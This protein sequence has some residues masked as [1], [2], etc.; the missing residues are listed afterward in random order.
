MRSDS[1]PMRTVSCPETCNASR[2]RPVR[3]AMI[4]RSVAP[5]HTRS[6]C[7]RIRVSKAVTGKAA[8]KGTL[9]MFPVKLLGIVCL[10]LLAPNRGLAIGEKSI[11]HYLRCLSPCHAIAPAEIW[12]VLGVARLVRDR[13]ARIARHNA[14]VGKLH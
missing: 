5:C 6:G 13:A 8:L 11:G 3:S 2:A 14:P 10:K 12:T 7:V 9:P 1:V 4:D